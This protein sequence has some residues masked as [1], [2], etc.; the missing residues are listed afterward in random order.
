MD[1]S[2][3]TG[4]PANPSTANATHASANAGTDVHTW[5]RMWSNVSAFTIWADRI[6]V[7]DS[8]EVLSP[9]YAPEMTAPAVMAGDTPSRPAMPTRPTPIVPAVVHELPIDRATTPQISAV[10][11]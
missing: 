8:G 5:A 4:G 2:F 3:S 7:S 11:R 1:T 9:R 6:V 10:A